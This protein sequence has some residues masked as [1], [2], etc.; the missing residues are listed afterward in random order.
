MKTR[1][2]QIHVQHETLQEFNEMG[3]IWGL[4]GSTYVAPLAQ[5]CDYPL[6]ADKVNPE[7][8]KTP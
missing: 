1:W 3:G 4:V 5:I 7:R 6:R 2:R 8:N